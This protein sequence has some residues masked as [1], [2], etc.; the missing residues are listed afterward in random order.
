MEGL[1][2]RALESIE[3]N[4]KAMRACIMLYREVRISRTQKTIASPKINFIA[5]L[6]PEPLNP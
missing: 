6:N 3:L 2:F 1:G 4:P 5:A